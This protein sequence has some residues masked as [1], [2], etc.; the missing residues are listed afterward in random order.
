MAISSTSW[1]RWSGAMW[2]RSRS[3]PR[4]GPRTRLCA[5]HRTAAEVGSQPGRIGAR[6][7]RSRPAP[8]PWARGLGVWVGGGGWGGVD[9]GEGAKGP[10]VF[11]F[12]G[13]RG[14]A[15]RHGQGGAPN[16][17]FNRRLVGEGPQVKYY[18]SNGAA[19]I[20][21]EVLAT[22]ACTRH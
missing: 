5:S 13:G 3:T 10:V 11:G 21:L 15:G 14:W 9:R 1:R 7:D 12:G 20:R 17:L 6:S 16:L 19:E 22:V 8:S 18:V 2:S 4:S